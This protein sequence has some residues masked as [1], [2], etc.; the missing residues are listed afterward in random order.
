MIN[1]EREILFDCSCHQ[2]HPPY[3]LIHTTVFAYGTP[4]L[5]STRQQTPIVREQKSLSI[6]IGCLLKILGSSNSVARERLQCIEICLSGESTAFNATLSTIAASVPTHEVMQDYEDVLRD[7]KNIFK[8]NKGITFATFAF[9]VYTQAIWFLRHR[10]VNSN[11][12]ETKIDTMPENVINKFLEAMVVGYETT[13]DTLYREAASMLEM[14]VMDLAKFTRHT[15]S[16]KNYREKI[17]DFL[18]NFRLS[19]INVTNGL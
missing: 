19:R 10:S 17:D 6:E 12:E 11:L 15:K 16:V 1:N 2:Y 3:N 7:A 13:P 9:W 8:K 4:Y 5:L 18:V 14:C